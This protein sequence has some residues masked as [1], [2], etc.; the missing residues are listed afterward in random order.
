MSDKYLRDE[1]QQLLNAIGTEVCWGW[2]PAI[3]FVSLLDQRLAQR[4][5]SCSSEAAVAVPASSTPVLSALEQHPPEQS[6]A[7][8]PAATGEREL[9]A[10]LARL[11]QRKMAAPQEPPPSTASAASASPPAPGSRETGALKGDVAVL[12][13]GACDVRHI[14]RTLASLRRREEQKEVPATSAQTYHFYLYEPNLRLHCRHL[15]FLQWLLDSMF[16]L[17]E[18][19]DRVLM[20]LD[21]FGNAL[22]RDST[23]AQARRVVQRLLQGLEKEEESPLLRLVSFSEMKLKE[24]DFVEQ[25]LRHWVC[26]A[27]HAE[28]D[29]QWTQRLQREMAERYDNRDNLIDWDF[30]FRLTD[31]T[32]LLKF[33]EYRVWRNTGVAFDVSHINPR[34][35][36][37]YSYTVPNKTLCH[38]DRLGHGTYCGDVKCGPFF[39]LGAQTANT[40]IHHR[41]ADGTCKYGNG[42]VA[43]HNVRAW[44]YTL[45][46]GLAWPWAD[47]A[48][49]WD[50]A[51]NYNY[52]PPGTPASVEYAARFPRVRFHLVGLDFDRFAQHVH[53]GRHPCM[54]AAFFGT[55]CTHLMTAPNLAKLMVRGPHSVVIAETAKFVLDAEDEAKEAFVTRAT[56]LVAC[57]GWQRDEAVTAVL[58]Q[59]QPKPRSSE[60]GGS[61][62]PAQQLARKR[63]SSPYQLAFT[64]P[65]AAP[66]RAG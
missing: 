52:L 24:R 62:T 49:A 30:V 25:Q 11:Q 26:D 27:S 64:R 6:S 9:D 19:E 40:F 58:H 63:Y 48:F 17:E 65:L 7:Q 57:G 43:M 3:D 29:E 10:L 23:A 34:R 41:T 56:E 61:Q 32:N 42:V 46:T 36:F 1:R 51:A 8:V 13:A 60:E 45:M 44:L 20:F 38:F 59:D 2:S 53:E 37:T 35:G 21:V 16:A 5:A 31:Y 14:L 33:A 18:L 12:L 15:F 66:T 22:T 28:V 4:D 47:H 39:A 55:S 54:D 50:D